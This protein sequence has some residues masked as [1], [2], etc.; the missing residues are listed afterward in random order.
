MAQ[1]WLHV[2]GPWC[3][4]KVH[5]CG[6][7]KN[8]W[9]LIG[10]HPPNP[11]TVVRLGELWSSRCLQAPLPWKIWVAKHYRRMKLWVFRGKKGVTF[12][13][14]SHI[15]WQLIKSVWHSYYMD[16]GANYEG[17]MK[18]SSTLLSQDVNNIHL[19]KSKAHWHMCCCQMSFLSGPPCHP[20]LP[21]PPPPPPPPPPQRSPLQSQKPDTATEAP[22]QSMTSVGRR[23]SQVYDE[24]NKCMLM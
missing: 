20:Q 1:S 6:T 17:L 12:K 2:C 13:V 24:R 10:F 8:W 19:I 3:N 22:H 9:K 4:A 16:H 14:S 7:E 23:D 11:F 21:L 15:C 5:W 18:H